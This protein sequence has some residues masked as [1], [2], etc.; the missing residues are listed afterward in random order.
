MEH[1]SVTWLPQ[2]NQ[3]STNVLIADL[4]PLDSFP[5]RDLLALDLV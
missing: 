1:R 2:T 3:Q 5:L 4:Q